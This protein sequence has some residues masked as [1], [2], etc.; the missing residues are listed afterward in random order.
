MKLTTGYDFQGYLIT[1]YLDVIFDEMLVGIGFLKGIVSSVDNVI[2]AFTGSE[3]TEM[4]NKLNTV[5]THL[6]DR[7]IEKAEAL[8][9]DALIGIDFESSRLGDLIMVSMTATAVKIDKIVSP[10]P[11]TQQAQELA[12][13]KIRKEHRE[14]ERAEQL[15]YIRSHLNELDPRQ[16]IK[17]VEQFSSTKEMFEYVQ[18][19]ANEKAEVF[20]T[21]L[22]QE[23]EKCMRLERM[24]GRGFGNNSIIKMLKNHFGID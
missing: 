6:R 15:E 21:E 16:F 10:L 12:A 24:Y 11:I 13:E 5:K 14:R 9:A 4:I 7:V 3:A 18:S 23:M 19:V 20:P 22:L 17:T 2:S 1:E 8:G